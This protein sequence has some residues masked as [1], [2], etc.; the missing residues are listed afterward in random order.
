MPCLHR[1]KLKRQHSFTVTPRYAVSLPRM[2]SR[3]W[4]DISCCECSAC[5]WSVPTIRTSSTGSR[6]DR[7]RVPAHSLCREVEQMTTNMSEHG[8]TF[9]Y[10]APAELFPT[11]SRKGNRP[12]GYRRFATAAEAIR[13][14]IEELSPELLVGA[15]LEVEEDRFDSEGI[16]R[17]YER[18]EY[19]LI[20]RA[21]SSTA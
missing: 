11:R 15:H 6:R 17:L 7:R 8:G 21:R 18:S 16:R 10:D 9:D 13:F 2:P 14:A 1:L 19:P 20:R 4:I 5:G 12:M 3:H